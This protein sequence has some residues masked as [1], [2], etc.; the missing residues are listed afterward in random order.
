MNEKLDITVCLVFRTLE[1]D[2]RALQVLQRCRIIGLQLGYNCQS[3]RH[4]RNVCVVFD[5]ASVSPHL[6]YFLSKICKLKSNLPCFTGRTKNKTFIYF[7]A[8]TGKP[9]SALVHSRGHEFLVQSD[10]VSTVILL[11]QYLYTHRGI[12]KS[13]LYHLGP[14]SHRRVTVSIV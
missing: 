1:G 3:L 13:L 10:N 14:N 6:Y 8:V 9:C 11:M 12:K 4:L 7:Y 2:D 5:E